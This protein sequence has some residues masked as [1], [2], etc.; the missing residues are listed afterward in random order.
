MGTAFLGGSEASAQEHT[1]VRCALKE[2]FRVAKMLFGEDLGGSHKCRLI[3]VLSR[4]EHRDECDDRFAASD[5]ALDQTVH[6]GIGCHI[7]EYRPD[8]PLLR[9]RE[10]EGQQRGNALFESVA[11]LDDGTLRLF[12]TFAFKEPECVAQPEKF[13]EYQTLLCGRAEAFVIGDR[14]ILRRE[15]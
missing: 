15:M 9:S 12:L 6:R 11:D 8:H 3:A 13:F 2:L 1:P 5:I 7:G 10:L 14:N 4:G